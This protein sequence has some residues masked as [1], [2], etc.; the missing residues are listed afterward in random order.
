MVY[1]QDNFL[2]L[3][4]FNWLSDKAK[5]KSNLSL[6]LSGNS[7]NRDFAKFHK[8]DR[9]GW[10]ITYTE[11]NGDISIPVME[12]GDKVEDILNHIKN[13]IKSVTGADAPK[14][15]NVHFIF[16]K[17]GYIVKQHTDRRFQNTHP[18]KLSK[19]Y[20]TFIF[21]NDVWDE[22]WG[23]ELCF[24]SGSFLPIPNRLVMYSIDEMHWV[25]KVNEN[26]II[27]TNFGCRFGQE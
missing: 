1:T 26:N 21:C 3:E 12:I 5:L 11:L 13:T 2:P 17:T 19:I 7:N 20:K 4:L 10:D 8:V 25:K 23:G 15:D 14:I 16:S 6:E 22:N 27:R 18:M 9:T 24:N